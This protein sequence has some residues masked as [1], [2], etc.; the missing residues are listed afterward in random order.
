VTV[1]TFILQFITTLPSPF[2]CIG[3]NKRHLFKNIFFIFIPLLQ[4]LD[5]YCE[6]HMS[7]TNDFHWI[8]ALVIQV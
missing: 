5:P 8:I 1:K 7:R 2:Y 4:T 3:E 6:E